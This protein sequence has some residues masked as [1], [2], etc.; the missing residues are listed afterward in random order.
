MAERAALG[1]AG[2]TDRWLRRRGLLVCTDAL[3]PRQDCA[4]AF[5]L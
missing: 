1:A 5:S 3:A 4:L 2:A